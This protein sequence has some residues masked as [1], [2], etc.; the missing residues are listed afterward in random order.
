MFGARYTLRHV[1]AASVPARPCPMG[2]LTGQTGMGL[3][4]GGWKLGWFCSRGRFAPA[5]SPLHLAR[6]SACR[7]CAFT[8][9]AAAMVPPP[10]PPRP[11]HGPA[12]SS[13]SSSQ[14]SSRSGERSSRHEFPPAPKSVRV[15]HVPEAGISPAP[16]PASRPGND[17]NAPVPARATPRLVWVG[18]LVLGALLA[19]V[20]A[21]LFLGNQLAR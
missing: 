9:R 10:P 7:A 13:S 18:I 19:L 16:E 17:I 8:L 6:P 11:P 20:A 5:L 4:A 21:L 14:P 1:F 12:S 15:W 3:N 2:G